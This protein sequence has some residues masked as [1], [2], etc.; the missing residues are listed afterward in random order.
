MKTTMYLDGLG[1]TS[2]G[3][4][5]LLGTFVGAFQLVRCEVVRLTAEAAPRSHDWLKC[6]QLVLHRVGG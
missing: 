1:H 3:R 5:K 2:G 6:A 4:V